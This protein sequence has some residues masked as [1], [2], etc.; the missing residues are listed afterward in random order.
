MQRERELGEGR[1]ILAQRDFETVSFVCCQFVLRVIHGGVLP[2]ASL[3]SPTFLSS[4]SSICMHLSTLEPPTRF[5]P[6]LF[7]FNPSSN[8]PIYLENFEIPRMDIS[9]LYPMFIL[10]SLGFTIL[11]TVLH[12]RSKIFFRKYSIDIIFGKKLRNVEKKRYVE[13]NG[14]RRKFRYTKLYIRNKKYPKNF[15][16]DC[17]QILSISFHFIRY[18]KWKYKV[19]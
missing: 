19:F 16:Q 2:V 9:S 1:D 8:F 15:Q 10:P 7:P 4:L 3:L 12:S 18:L 14:Q 13:N 5:L 17:T 11:S 6:S